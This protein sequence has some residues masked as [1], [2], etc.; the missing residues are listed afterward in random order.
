MI[1]PSGKGT[2]A[3]QRNI[4]RFFKELLKQAVPEIRFHDLWHTAATLMLLNGIPVMIVSR[5]LGHSKPSVTLDI[6]GHY[7]PGMQKEAATLMDEL[8]TPI[9][10]N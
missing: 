4:N 1:F 6:Y 2:P 9:A 3:D 8:V 5:R 10:A 7:L